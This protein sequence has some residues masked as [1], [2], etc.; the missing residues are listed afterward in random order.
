M[1]RKRLQFIGYERLDKYNHK[2]KGEIE[3]E[4]KRDS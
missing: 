3:I 2:F 4:P 1:I